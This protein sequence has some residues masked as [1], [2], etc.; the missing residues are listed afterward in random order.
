MA[1]DQNLH[2]APKSFPAHLSTPASID[3]PASMN[4]ED[5]VAAFE[6]RLWS[7]AEAVIDAGAPSIAVVADAASIVR[8]QSEMFASIM[9]CTA[10][11]TALGEDAGLRCEDAVNADIAATQDRL[12]RRLQEDLSTR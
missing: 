2:S 3:V 7:A 11:M 8:R 5:A 1:F 10:Y 12:I 4:I 9:S 6:D